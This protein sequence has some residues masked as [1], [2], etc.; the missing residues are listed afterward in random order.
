MNKIKLADGNW[1][2]LEDKAL[3]LHKGYTESGAIFNEEKWENA[4]FRYSLWRVWDPGLPR[5]TFIMLNCS[6]GNHF[7]LTRSSR[8]CDDIAKFGVKIDGKI[9][10]FGSVEVVNLFAFRTPKPE[11]LKNEKG[12]VIGENN[13][14]YIK[15]ALSRS[16]IAVVAWGKNGSYKMRDIS[17]LNLIKELGHRPYRITITE[18]MFPYHPSGV[19]SNRGRL[20]LDNET[21]L[22][23]V[24]RC[25]GEYVE[26]PR[27]HV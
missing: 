27:H 18:D 26:C 13:D 20:F 23:F 3:A 8:Y 6:M 2:F 12:D 10:K 11:I 15:L 21:P 1:Q 5:I 4:R 22:K 25:F 7:K 19:L 14:D 16:E 24:E 17:V 9:I